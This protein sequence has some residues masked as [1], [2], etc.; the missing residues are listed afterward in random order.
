MNGIERII[1]RI[2][3]EAQ[4]EAEAVR[5]EA[6][7]TCDEIRKADDQKA[8]EL[9]WNLVRGGVKDCEARVQRLGS[10]AA[11][12][13]KKSI[14]AL[15]QE[16]VAAAF[17]RAEEMLCNLPEDEYV[18]LLARLAAD[19]AVTG[20]EELVFNE[21]DCACVGEKVAAAANALLAAKGVNGGLTVCAATRGIK[22]GLIVRQGDIETNCSVEAM[23]ELYRSALAAQVASA[24]FED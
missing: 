1:A 8:Q 19:A 4:A 2:E 3:R 20:E 14:L 16:M 10:T 17:R 11:M 23:T 22:G 12:E 9:Y 5:A 13:A 18:S 6:A 7:Q 15:K 24:L 21:K